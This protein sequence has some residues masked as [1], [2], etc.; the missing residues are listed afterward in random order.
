ML[1]RSI[2][3]A[4]LLIAAPVAA[5]TNASESAK[6][7]N[8]DPSVLQSDDGVTV[9][10]E[11]VEGPPET[12][13]DEAVVAEEAPPAPEP[14]LEPKTASPTGPLTLDTPIAALIADPHGKAV[15]D[16]DLPGLSSD[17]NLAKF[18]GKSLHQFQ[19]LTGGQLTDAMLAKVAADLVGPR[20]PSKPATR[21]RNER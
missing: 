19:P 2:V 7:F 17:E 15:L 4:T 8:L 14:K 9:P 3:T 10:A 13:A 16:R 21:R 1:I 6:K 20:A 5:Q 18:S 11:R 12:P